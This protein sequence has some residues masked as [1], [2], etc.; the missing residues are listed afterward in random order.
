[1][2]AWTPPLDQFLCFLI[3]QN[4]SVGSAQT[5]DWQDLQQDRY[6]EG[7]SEL[8]TAVQLGHLQVMIANC[9]T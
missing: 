3:A 8:Q 1:M 4:N 7:P 9:N 6:P 2:A 5:L